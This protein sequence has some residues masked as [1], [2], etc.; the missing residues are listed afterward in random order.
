[1]MPTRPSSELKLKDKMSVLLK[2]SITAISL[3]VVVGCAS[4][5]IDETPRNDGP[6]PKALAAG[7]IALV[8]SDSVNETIEE[9]GAYN[10]YYKNG[11]TARLYTESI[12]RA[13]VETSQ[14]RFSVEGVTRMLENR[15]GEVRSFHSSE[16]AARSG[17][18]L[19][20]IL[21]MEVQLI[22][23]RGSDPFSTLSLAFKKSD[24]GDLGAIHGTAVVDFEPLWPRN[25]REHEIVADIR[26][27]G[28]VQRKALELLEQRLME[29]PAQ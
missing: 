28:K 7:P 5:H 23:G 4:Q 1:M 14:P 8:I 27:Q 3:V 19:I 20:A 24:G 9:L 13:Y 10:S 11:L 15:F 2:R 17:L 21:S 29:I 22:D 6:A 18:P 26:Q 12:R 25:K 16:D